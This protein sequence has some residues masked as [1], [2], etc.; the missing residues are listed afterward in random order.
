MMT[1]PVGIEREVTSLRWRRFFFFPSVAACRHLSE[2]RARRLLFSI[3]TSTSTNK[4]VQPHRERSSMRTTRVFAFRRAMH[5]EKKWLCGFLHFCK[6]ILKKASAHAENYC[7]S[8]KQRLTRSANMLFVILFNWTRSRPTAPL[9]RFCFMRSRHHYFAA[10][11]QL[12]SDPSCQ[13]CHSKQA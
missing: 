1:L 3:S 9:F 13:T 12:R 5:H 4:S 8:W 2:G 11:F 6:K 10:V 7:T